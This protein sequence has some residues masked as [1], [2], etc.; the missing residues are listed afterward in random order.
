[1]LCC[2]TKLFFRKDI[3][4]LLLNSIESIWM[5]KT[6]ITRLKWFNFISPPTPSTSSASLVGSVINFAHKF[7]SDFYLTLKSHLKK[8]TENG[9]FNLS[10][11]YFVWILLFGTSFGKFYRDKDDKRKISFFHG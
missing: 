5:C 1:M 2:F 6:F 10:S 7:E 4:F 11:I 8:E 9:K 3:C